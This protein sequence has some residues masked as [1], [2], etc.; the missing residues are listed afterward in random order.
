MAANIT[1]GCVCGAVRYECS[2]EPV[3]TGNCHCRDCQKAG[4]GAFAPALG[5][6]ASA[7]KITG[8]V[9]YYDTKADSG[10]VVSRGFCPECGARLFGKSNGMPDLQIVLAGSLDDP[11]SFRPGMDLYTSSAQP[12]DNMHAELPKFAK[13]PPMQS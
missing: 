5:V 2:A 1:G 4:G 13:M 7:L 11:S 9:K 6:P 10:N 3:L 8:K 12:W